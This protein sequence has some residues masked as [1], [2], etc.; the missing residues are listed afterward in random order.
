M[1]GLVTLI[2]P[3]VIVCFLIYKKKPEWI[4]KAKSWLGK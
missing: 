3:L 1:E 2:V 4:A